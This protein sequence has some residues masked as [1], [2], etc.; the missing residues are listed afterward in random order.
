MLKSKSSVTWYWSYASIFHVESF[1]DINAISLICVA[2][3][4]PSRPQR[5]VRVLVGFLC[6]VFLVHNYADSDA[7]CVL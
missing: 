3:R 7:V 4:Q 5:C 6:F 1:L 2:V